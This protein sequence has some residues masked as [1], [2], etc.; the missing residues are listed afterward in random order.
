MAERSHGVRISIS[1]LFKNF[2]TQNGFVAQVPLELKNN[3]WSVV[4]IDLYEIL[5]QSK[6]MP[7][8]YLIDGSYQIRSINVCAN[9]HIRGV[10]T[11]DNMYDFVTLPADMRYKFAFDL[12]KWPEYF[13]W[14]TLP[15]DWKNRKGQ[16][17][18][19]PGDENMNLNALI[20]T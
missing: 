14:Q 9:T 2:N 13:D 6:I 12:S 19:Y 16:H 10:F 18:E 11:S 3:C 8:T 1:N 20:N 5:K 15:H 7:S 17:G 4:V